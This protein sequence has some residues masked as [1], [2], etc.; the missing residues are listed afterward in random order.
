MAL[1]TVLSGCRDRAPRTA[2]ATDSLPAKDSVIQL[3]WQPPWANQG[4]LVAIL[5]KTDLLA[6]QGVNVEFVP[7]T[8]GG[9]MVEAA[10]ANRLD[11]VFAGEQPVLNLLSRNGDWRIVARMVRYRSAVVVPRNSKLQ[12]LEDLKGRS[13]FTAIGSTTHRD[14]IRILA[15]SGMEGQVKVVGLDQAEHASFIERGGS[16]DWGECAGVATYDPT[17]AAALASGKARILH[18]WASPALVA[19]HKSMTEGRR[20]SLQAFLRAY[21]QSYVRYASNPS[22]ANRWYSAES[23]LT[24]SDEQYAEIAKFE[25]NMSAASEEDVKVGVT[26]EIVA[27]TKKNAEIAAGL[28]LFKNMGTPNVEGMSVRGLIPP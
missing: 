7:F 9:P 26:D 15:E 2:Q 1:V 18:A 19:A 12:K 5:K 21:R 3:G 13:V 22:E 4:Q 24:L 17:I 23:R 11:I 16:E 20:E 28:G 25:P 27:A 6:R 8:Y 10:A 14:L